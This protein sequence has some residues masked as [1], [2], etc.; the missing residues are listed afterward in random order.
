MSKLWD[1]IY[2]RSESTQRRIPIFRL[3][4][5]LKAYSR[6]RR[7]VEQVSASLALTQDDWTAISAILGPIEQISDPVRRAVATDELLGYMLDAEA[8]N[9]DSNG[10]RVESN[11]IALAAEVRDHWN[12]I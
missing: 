8:D 9:A 1:D 2:S 3:V 4:G 6:G 5:Q 12:S 7:T 11:F 10:W